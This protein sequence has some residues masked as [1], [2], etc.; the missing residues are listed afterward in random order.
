MKKEELISLGI[1]EEVAKQIMSL[2][3]NDIEAT[4]AKADKTQEIEN[5]K[6]ELESN[7]Q[8]LE[9]ANVQIEKFKGLD[10]E[11]IKA[12]AEEWKNKYADFETKSKADKEAYE[13][14]IAD[15]DYEFSVKEIVGKHKFESEWAKE[16]FTN[17]LKSKGFKLEEGK[18][19]GADDYIKDFSEKNKGIFVVEEAPTGETPPPQFTTDKPS[20]ATPPENANWFGWAPRK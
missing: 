14:A 19:L 20:Q 2:N 6:T 16:Q 18:L 4:K 3:G 7:K 17:T 13:K 1:D 9:Q 11:G 10:V 5:L 15:K 8:T 12:Q